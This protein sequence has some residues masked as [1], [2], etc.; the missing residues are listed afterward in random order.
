MIRVG[1]VL[2]FDAT[3]WLGGISYFRNLLGALVSLPN[4]RIVPVILAGKRTDPSVLAQFPVSPAAHSAMLDMGTLPWQIRRGAAKV[5]GRD[6]GLESLLQHHDIQVLSHQGFLGGLGRV[7]ALGWIPDFQERH[8]P[9]FFSSE[10]ISARVRKRMLFSRVCSRVILSSHDAQNDLRALDADCAGRSRVLQFVADVA[11]S[12]QEESRSVTGRLNIHGP[13]FHLPNQ[14]WVHKNH[15]VVIAALRILKDRGVNARVIA[16]GNTADHRQPGAYTALMTRV[17]E[18]NVEDRFLSAGTVS[19]RD[20][21]ALMGGSVAVINPSRFEGWSTTVEEAKSLGKQVLL[22]DLR[23]H[24]EQAPRRSRY[25]G[26]DDA[27]GLAEAMRDTLVSFDPTVE[28]SA[29]HE[30]QALLPERRRAFARTYE[31]IVLEA[32]R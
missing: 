6:R 23:V 14:F 24:R 19:Y 3:G 5:L 12:S 26:P 29:I 18:A 13:Y 20:L 4:P 10:E 1:F 15:D 8:L 31:D 9:E 27:E 17:R 7:P 28:Q 21:L 25:F 2:T 30:A 22:S 11:A 32:V 16:S